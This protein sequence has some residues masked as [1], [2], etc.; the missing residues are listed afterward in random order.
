MRWDIPFFPDQASTMAE[1]VDALYFFLVALSTFF[2]LLIAGLLIYFA[3]RYRRR[4]E[5]HIPEPMHG[6]LVL[7]LTWTL[8]PL[9]LSMVIFVWGALLF[10]AQSRVPKNAIDI[11][12]VAKQWMWKFQ[13]QDGRR[14]INELH[15]PI[16]RAVRLTMASED[17]IHSFYVPA[18]RLKRDVLP[19]RFS[20]MWFEAT[21]TGSFHLFC[22]E[23][24][25]TRHSRMIGK[26]VVM[27]PL[28]YQDW[29]AGGN[30][31]ETLAEAGAR[32]FQQN[33][34]VT[35]HREG[36]GARGPS[37]A[38][39]FGKE[40]PLEGGGTVVAD[41]QYLRESIVNPQAKVVSGFGRIM[42]TY[43][44]LITEEGLLQLVAHIKSM[45]SSSEATP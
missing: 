33:A 10:F 27:R 23:F 44:G 15:V 43:Q 40:V 8:I 24:C 14:E 42:P 12:V 19:G 5:S 29:L 7:E 16:G 25:G 4:V 22:A 30:S 36:A 39:L 45:Q 28:E 1:R 26:V 13:H 41:E 20:T 3:A 2:A 17:V 31:R 9:A 35:C 11:A 37:L 6:S 18:F 21:Q 34:C 38:G 32:L